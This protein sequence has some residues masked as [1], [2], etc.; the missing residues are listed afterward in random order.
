MQNI[1]SIDMSDRKFRR[2]LLKYFRNSV[3]ED[4]IKREFRRDVCHLCRVEFNCEESAWSHY[5]SSDHSSRLR[6][7]PKQIEK[8]TEFWVMI[9]KALAAFDPDFI[10]IEQLIDHIL[11]KFDVRFIKTS[12]TELSCV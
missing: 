9:I 3:A 6:K 10:S 11:E 5:R 8:A 4:V 2:D 1:Q 12:T 7:V